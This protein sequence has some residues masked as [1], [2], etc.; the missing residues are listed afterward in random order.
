MLKFYIM[1]GTKL[2]QKIQIVTIAE[3]QLLLLQ[4]AKFH[5]EG[6]QNITGSVESGETFLEAAIRELHE[7][8]GISGNLIDLQYEFT[9][10]ERWGADVHEK[11]FLCLLDK[12]P[13]ITLSHEHQSFKWIP[14]SLVTPDNYVFPTNFEAFTKALENISK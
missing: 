6:F 5:N 2:K 14:V 4:F 1:T 7:E 13:T 8:T 10:H 12:I 11:V 9:F 3:N